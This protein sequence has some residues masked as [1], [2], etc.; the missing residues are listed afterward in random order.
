MK[1]YNVVLVKKLKSTSLEVNYA[2][3]VCKCLKEIFGFFCLFAS[4]LLLEG[5]FFRLA[6]SLEVF[7]TSKGM[8]KK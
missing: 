1:I 8:G 4:D 5:S 7:N 2:S 3:E 6:D